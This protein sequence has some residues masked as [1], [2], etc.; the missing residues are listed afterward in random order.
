M[1]QDKFKSTEYFLEE[2]EYN[3]TSFK[4]FKDKISDPDIASEQKKMLIYTV[5]RRS[6]E[7]LVMQYC[8]GSNNETKSTYLNQA[9]SDLDLYLD[10]R[11]LKNVDVEP[12]S[13]YIL[14][15]SLL[16]IAILLNLEP[17]KLDDLKAKL[18][19]GIE[20]SFAYQ[21]ATLKGQSFGITEKKHNDFYYQDM[22]KLFEP[23]PDN[24]KLDIACNY[25]NKK[26][27]KALKE[28]YWYDTHKK[29]DA[30]FFG[31]F[32]FEIAAIFTSQNIDDSKLR[33]IIY[34][35]LT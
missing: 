18:F 11:E 23:I 10:I 3:N 8:I 2:I 30:G 1:K 9:T 5:F 14:S 33:E 21:L 28:T 15:T 17:E 35:P 19:G 22:L 24:E 31:Y 25:L 34:Y 7:Q 20:D 13:D 6:I 27:Y 16:S 12:I 29:D 26:Y 32:C 4:Q